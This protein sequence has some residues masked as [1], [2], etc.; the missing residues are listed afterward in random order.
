M[1]DSYIGY[2]KYK[3]ELVADGVMDARK[4]A[5]AL[6]GLDSA[7][8]YFVGK[9]APDF[10]DV[11]YEIPVKVNKGS[12]E[13]LIPETIGGW[14]QAGLGVVATAYFSQ[15]AQKM[16]EKDFKDFGFS[17]VFRKSIQG[18]KWFVK[19]SKHLGSAT[20]KKFNNVMFS[21]DGKS[22]G[23]PNDDGDFLFVPK[24]MLELYVSAS[25]LLIEKLAENVVSGRELYIGTICR[26]VRDEVVVDLRD[27]SIFCKAEEEDVDD[28]LFPELVHGETVVLEGEV[29]RENKTTNS[30]GFKYK[31]HILSS[32]PQSGSIVP[33]KQLLFLRCRIYAVVSRMD[34]DG[35]PVARKPK[36]YF[37]RIEPL[38][39]EPQ[40][41]DLF[42]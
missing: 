42:G 1:S 36:L 23:I 20:V 21:K 33:Y 26:G 29:T 14:V 18:V 39:D 27:K 4:Q 3:G 35:R 17:D 22:V 38:Y 13:A 10:K 15:A 11:D 2:I 25:P 30:M 5:Q 32:Y 7:L 6:L 40:E 31:E 9:F 24:E 12:W 34:E 19:I 28:I 41:K 37:S 8:R 16:A